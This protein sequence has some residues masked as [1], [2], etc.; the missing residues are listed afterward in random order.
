MD[1]HW[2][3]YEDGCNPAEGTSFGRMR[4]HKIWLYGAKDA[5]NV[6]ECHKIRPQTDRSRH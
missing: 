2:H 1:A 4:V 5:N 3:T 6:E